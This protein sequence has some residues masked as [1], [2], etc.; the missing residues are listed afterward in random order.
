MI[1]DWLSTETVSETYFGIAQ[2]VQGASLKDFLSGK[3]AFAVQSSPNQTPDGFNG[4][5]AQIVEALPKQEVT[6]APAPEIS[7]PKPPT[8]LA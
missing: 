1:K 3:N 7:P 4:I 6:P 2:A 5:G 8:M